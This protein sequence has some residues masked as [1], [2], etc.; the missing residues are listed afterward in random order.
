MTIMASDTPEGREARAAMGAASGTDLAGYEMQL[1]STK[2][3]FAP[4]DAAAFARSEDL[5]KTMN[6]VRTF[7]FDHGLLGEGAPSPDV[8][9]IA[10]PDGS[11]QG[12]AGNVKFRFVTDY[13]DAAAKGA[14]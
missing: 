11:V 4:A 8:V 2:M 13:M 5:P 12:D 6:A 3:F 10:Y 14:L 1:D 9:G 7:L